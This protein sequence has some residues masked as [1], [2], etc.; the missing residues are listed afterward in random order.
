MKLFV[1]AN[2]LSPYALS[3]YVALRE[4]GLPFE[5][6]PVDL[7]AG[8]HRTG[9]MSALSVTLRVPTL[10]D[11]DFHLSESS[12][13]AE[14][15]E[16]ACPGPRLYPADPK[17]RA[18]AREIQ[19]W[20]RSDLLPL[21]MERSTEVVFREVTP[22]PLSDAAQAAADKLVRAAERLLPPGSAHL[23][24]EWCIADTDL[25][26]MLQRLLRAGDAVPERLAVYANSQW[27][28]PAVQEW[29]A[30]GRNSRGVL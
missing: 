21:R 13:I 4:K 14:Y 23:F 30:L 26:L 27:Q 9:A 6:V 2:F 15:L 7:Q 16:D 12:A 1:D 5:T 3:A 8:A 10:S 29:L 24:G 19:A 17:H 11:G 28:R 20:I 18:K 25:A 22:P